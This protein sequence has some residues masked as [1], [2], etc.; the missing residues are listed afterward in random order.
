[1]KSKLKT[2]TYHCFI[3]VL[4]ILFGL[5]IVCNYLLKALYINIAK[6]A[7]TT[8]QTYIPKN[9]VASASYVY[10]LLRCRRTYIEIRESEYLRI[11]L[12]CHHHV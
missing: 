2:Y 3:I 10:T 11:C 8:P 4:F 6:Q 7:F 12:I 1:M 9:I 5:I